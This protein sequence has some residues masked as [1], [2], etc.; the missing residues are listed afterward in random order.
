MNW[1]LIWSKNKFFQLL[2]DYPTNNIL[3]FYNYHLVKLKKK[4]K[5][6]DNGCGGGR[7]FKF[8]TNLGFD[9]YG[10]DTSKF[11]INKNKKKFKKYK[12][13]FFLGDIRALNFEENYFDVIVSEASLYYQNVNKFYKLLKKDGLIRV[14]TKSINDNFFMNFDKRLSKEIKIKKNHWEKNLT[15]SFLSLN[16]VK[17]IFKNFRKLQIGIDEFNY[18]NYKKKHSSYIITATK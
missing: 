4:S 9:V 8:L 2:D 17:S 14:H 3:Y 13:K 18:I 5:I 16:D 10:T 11:I 15:L 1:N 12:S 7:N 6:L